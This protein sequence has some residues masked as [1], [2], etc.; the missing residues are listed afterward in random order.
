MPGS[1]RALLAVDRRPLV[2]DRTQGERMKSLLSRGLGIILLV[3]VSLPALV[4]VA[5][6]FT[7]TARDPV[8]VTTSQ[9]LQPAFAT[10]V[11]NGAGDYLGGSNVGTSFQ[12]PL[13]R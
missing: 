3:I 8:N 13:V 11:V 9:T 1:P 6:Q 4:L 10:P 5:P 2:A 7:A 12:F